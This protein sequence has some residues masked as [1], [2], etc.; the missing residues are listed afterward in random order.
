MKPDHKTAAQIARIPLESQSTVDGISVLAPDFCSDRPATGVEPT[1]SMC[2][3]DQCF[4]VVNDRK[5]QPPAGYTI[6]MCERCMSHLSPT[7]HCGRRQVDVNVLE[8]ED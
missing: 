7:R 3:N 6:V 5:C 8:R 2:V 4:P 1:V